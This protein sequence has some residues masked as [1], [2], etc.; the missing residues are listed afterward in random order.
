MEYLCP[1]CGLRAIQRI[2]DGDDRSHDTALGLVAG[3]TVGG[4]V[5]GPVGAAIGALLGLFI[6]A[7]HS[8]P[9]K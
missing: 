5:G 3:A 2:P 1:V 7:Q 9:G 6:G 8:K 4:V